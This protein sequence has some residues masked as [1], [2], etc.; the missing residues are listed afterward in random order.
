MMK[1]LIFFFIVLFTLNVSAQSPGGVSG[2][3]L[4]WMKADAETYEDAPGTDATEDTDDVVEW[5]DQSG[6][7]HDATDVTGWYPE[8]DEDAFNFNPG[9]VFTQSNSDQL[10]IPNGIFDANAITGASAYVVCSH[11]TGTNSAVFNE[12]LGPDATDE[13]MFLAPWSTDEV[14]WQV[15]TN[16]VGDGRATDGTW[17]GS[18]DGTQYIW[19]MGNNSSDAT[20]AGEEQY[21]RLDGHIVDTQ[22]GYDAT[23]VGN[24]NVF[25]IGKWST[26]ANEFDGTI[27]ELIVYDKILSATEEIQVQSYLALKYGI[28][29]NDDADNDA[30]FGDVVTGSLHEGD[31]LAADG[32]T[33][34]WDYDNDKLFHF[35]VAGIGADAT[36]GLDQRISKSRNSDAIVTMC[37]EAIGTL[38]SSIGTALTDDA[39]LLWGNNNAV[40]SA[41]ADLPSGYTGR[42]PKE[43]I[44]KMTGTVSNI[45]VQFDLPIGQQ[46][47]GDA[48]GDYYLLIDSDGDFT[49]GATATA[50]SS[51]S[52]GKVT[53]NDINFTDGQYFTLATTQTAPGAVATHL[54]AWF[55]ADAETYEDAS[56][57]TDAA[58]DTDD[59]LQWHDQSGLSH[60]ATVATTNYPEYDEDGMNFNPAIDFENGNSDYLAV[61]GGL[62]GTDTRYKWTAYT[63]TN[64]ES[65]A[66]SPIFSEDL[67]SGEDLM[68]LAP[69]STDDYHWRVGS[70]SNQVWNG[71]GFSAAGTGVNVLWSMGAGEDDNTPGGEEMYTRLNA[72]LLHTRNAYETSV[73]GNSQN[74]LIGR[75]NGNASEFDGK[76]AELILYDGI[77]SALDEI[78]IQTYLAIKYGLTLTDDNDAD[79]SAGEAIGSVTEG[80]YVAGDGTTVLWDYSAN[81]A[82]HYDIAGL[83]RD[84]DMGLHQKQSKSSNSDA[85]V[86]MS[87]EAIGTTNAGIAT[88]LTND[89]YLIWGNNNATS[90][91]AD[92]DL[93]SGYTGRL[94]REWVVEMTGTVSNVHIEFDLS[95]QNTNLM[96]DAAGDFYLLTDADGDFT[97]GATATVATS[98]SGNKVTFDDFNF[99]DGQ[100]FT[101]ATQQA[102]PGGVGF[103]LHL[104]LE[105]ETQC[106]NT[107]TTQATD[108]Q[109]VDNWHDQS[110]NEFDISA[111]VNAAV[112][113]QDGINFRPS[114][115]FDGNDNYT[116][117]GGI[118]GTD[119][120]HNAFIYTVNSFDNTSAANTLFQNNSSGTN[121]TLWYVRG[122]ANNLTLDKGNITEGTGRISGSWGGTTTVPYLWNAG[123]AESTSTPSATTKYCSRN[124]TS[125][126]TDGGTDDCIGLGQDFYFGC[127]TDNSADFNGKVSEVLIFNTILSAA[128][129][130]RVQTYLAIK[131]GLT[132][133]SMDYLSSTGTAIWDNSTYSGYHNDIAGIGRDDLGNLL[134]KQSKSVNADAIVTMSTQ[135]IAAT[136]AANSTTLTDGAYLLWGNNNATSASAESDLPSGYTGRLNR[137]WVVEMTGTVSNVHIEFDL[138]DQHTNLMGDAAGDFYLLTDADGNFTSGATAT[139]ATSFSGNKVT[140]DD[141]T[142]TDGQYFTLASQQPGPG[143]VANGLHVWYEAGTQCHNTV[144][145]QATNA[146]D[147]NNWHDQS[148]NEFDQVSDQGDANWDED[149][150]NFRP[151]LVFDGTAESYTCASGIIGNGDT[152]HNCFTYFVGTVASNGAGRALF[153]EECND[154]TGDD[155]ELLFNRSSGGNI[156]LD[157]GRHTEATGRVIGSFG[158]T[159]DK[160]HIWT[161]GAGETTSTA[162]GTNKYITRDNTVVDTQDGTSTAEGEGAAFTLGGTNTGSNDWDGSIAELIILNTIPSAAEEDQI[163]SYLAIKYGLQMDNGFSFLNSAGTT[164]W[165]DD[166]TYDD[167]FVGIARDDAGM[168]DQRQSKSSESDAVLTLSTQAIAATSAANTTQLGTD[169]SY[170]IAAHNDGAVDVSTSELHATFAER[171]TRE[172][173]V[174]ESGTVGNVLVEMDITGLT[175]T[176]EVA[177]N[178]GLVIDDDGDF[179]G[180]TQSYYIANDFSSDKVTFNTVDF[181]DGKYFTLMNSNSALPVELLAF[182]VEAEGCFAHLTWTTGSELNNDFFQVQYSYDGNSWTDLDKVYGAGNSDEVINYS[183]YDFSC[184]HNSTVYYRLVQTDFDGTETNS[185]VQS[186]NLTQPYSVQVY[187]NPS[188]GIVNVKLNAEL[189]DE[190]GQLT[191]RSID[192][193]AILVNEISNGVNT[194]NLSELA[195]DTYIIKVSVPDQLPFY[196][197][198][199]KVE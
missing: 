154:L 102:A 190:L 127:K 131:Y 114:L 194:I 15:G 135:A 197:K 143:G 69:W 6:N 7:S 199:V 24:N 11:G 56:P 180:G 134:Q 16:T 176:N 153:E 118:L 89:A 192:G 181:T 179:T 72:K 9:I 85:I 111:T 3:N 58:E 29:L 50:A 106:H 166:A 149:L 75:W 136:N 182:D 107:V 157:M 124:N 164:V 132:L 189:G 80:D 100:Y 140:F 14:F 184:F 93:P 78:K 150:I 178:F 163:Q 177:A 4:L 95:G 87:T 19:S 70:S 165:A 22:D 91:S 160:P 141:F 33:E 45:H 31:Y 137:E 51:F 172:W 174:A 66:N 98:F 104:W 112:W 116:H 67:A 32:T 151:A 128:E 61:S 27:A 76:I 38:N 123:S 167:G 185:N 129:E 96:G 156:Y 144:T 68:F 92:A 1:N 41:N 188:K 183:F 121:H 101:L 17:E 108:A 64:H 125:L 115:T 42:L 191:V 13:F 88:T 23:A 47:A 175:F 83:G 105:A 48:A 18:T 30:S 26:S 71:T 170:E 155:Y 94:N 147:V 52:T 161:A 81:T 54:E 117:V 99:T 34:I 84:D 36:S 145:T 62:M 130:D 110:G 109:T 86:T 59:V 12:P 40:A 159:L 97:S 74:F 138:S 168:L 103:G 21:I 119:T 39:Y 79:A 55:K 171:F 25:Y 186:I 10:R 65:T 133:A 49:S 8:F 196:Q 126:N 148:G 113:D 187:P 57:G 53:F 44:V 77:P 193:R 2:N 122:S 198:L 5:H 120:L 46:L 28:T 146:Q 158:G 142:F 73:V 173:K 35:D 152:L 37:T 195:P 43:W 139:A 90:T 63:V 82:Y 20:S 162:T 169:L 60:D